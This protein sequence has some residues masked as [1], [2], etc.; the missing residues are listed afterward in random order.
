MA[1]LTSDLSLYNLKRESCRETKYISLPVAECHYYSA[2]RDL[3][4]KMFQMSLMHWSVSVTYMVLWMA[5]AS[6][7]SEKSFEV[8]A[9]RRSLAFQPLQGLLLCSGF[10]EFGG[11]SKSST[12][13]TH[14]RITGPIEFFNQSHKGLNSDA[15]KYGSSCHPRELEVRVCG[16]RADNTCAFVSAP[17]IFRVAIRCAI[18]CLSKKM[19]SSTYP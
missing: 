6:L 2:E 3:L 14:Q 11:I 18:V 15:V 13:T 9:L 12:I 19:A 5:K 10:T 1:V 4:L 8:C 7:V 17:R 16:R